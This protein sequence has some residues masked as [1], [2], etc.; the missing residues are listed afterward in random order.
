MSRAVRQVYDPGL[1]VIVSLRAWMA[2][3]VP[4]CFLPPYILFS[5][6]PR[7]AILCTAALSRT[8]ANM[9]WSCMGLQLF[10]IVY[11]AFFAFGIRMVLLAFQVS[12]MPWVQALFIVLRKRSSRSL[13]SSFICLV[14]MWSGPGAAPF[15][16]CLIAAC[17]IPVLSGSAFAVMWVLALWC[18]PP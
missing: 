17:K 6:S 2:S 9:L 16:D 4:F 13:Q 8:L 1:F 15:G 7:S 18:S 3:V 12:G 10:A 5:S 11:V 14:V